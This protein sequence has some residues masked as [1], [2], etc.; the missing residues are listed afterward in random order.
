MYT[1]LIKVSP[2]AG[3]GWNPPHGRCCSV[4]LTSVFLEDCEEP[5]ESLETN[6]EPS[7]WGGGACILNKFPGICQQR[8]SGALDCT[9]PLFTLCVPPLVHMA[10]FMAAGEALLMGWGEF[11]GGS[12]KVNGRVSLGRTGSVPVSI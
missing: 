11:S 5:G 7:C 1:A 6:L 4:N 9:K 8:K 12:H 10:H 3:G 2:Y